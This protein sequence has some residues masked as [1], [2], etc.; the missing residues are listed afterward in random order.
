MKK[1]VLILVI[2]GA[3]GYGGLHF[4]NK[5]LIAQA[6]AAAPSRLTSAV[7]E[8]RNI[9]FAVSAAGEIGPAEQVSVRPEVNGKI[10]ELPVD[11]GD[12]VKKGQS[13]FTLDDHDLQIE[14]ESQEKDIERARLEM[15]QAE[16]NFTRADQLYR[17]H[18]ISQEV[19]ED[20]KTQFELSKNSLG[21]AEKTLDLVKERI[22]KTRIVAPFDCTVLTRP[23]SAGQAVSGS[24]GFNSGTEV[25]T[26]A[27]LHEMIINAHINQADV[28]RLKTG[29]DVEV[30]VEAVAGLTVTGRVQR[31]APQA[32]MKNNIKGFAARILLKDVDH[33]VRPGMTANIKIPVASADN[34]VSVPLA[35]I[36]S[37]PN[38]QSQQVERFV[39]VRKGESIEKRQVQIG[40]SDYF[41][42][43]VEKGLSAGEI[44]MLEEP[45]DEKIRSGKP[46]LLSKAPGGAS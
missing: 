11:I 37:E 12:T 21:R 23:V 26:I 45:K 46:T 22:S 42:A 27:D 1:V 13:L 14:R 20:V 38:P 6:A 35:A 43:E 2:L 9:R 29:L 16:R 19:Y 24:G 39:Y 44:V 10:S 36:F 34:V 28:T 8:T 25:L 32:T 4:Y 15:G 30:V 3:A 33:R 17:E 5:W 31:V 41:F 40:V 7:A 18:L